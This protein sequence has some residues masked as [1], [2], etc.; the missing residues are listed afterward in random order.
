MAKR[1]QLKKEGKV[2]IPTASMS[3]IA[4]LLLIFFMV[5]TTFRKEVGL[6]VLLPEARATEK[7]TRT[8]DISHIYISKDGKIS[9]D[10]KLVTPDVVKLAYARK[11]EEKPELIISIKADKNVKYDYVDKVIESLREAKALRVVFATNF[12]K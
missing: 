12:K 5:S 1:K 3:D 11:V 10:D 6:K 4:F 9:V 7:L 8:R 2:A